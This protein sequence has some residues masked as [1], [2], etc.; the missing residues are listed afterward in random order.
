MTEQQ[1]YIVLKIIGDVEIRTYSPY[2]SANI[3]IDSSY[4]KASNLGFRPLAN[5]IFS[6]GIGL[7]DGNGAFNRHGIPRGQTVC[8]DKDF[9]AFSYPLCIIGVTSTY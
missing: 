9:H 3:K 1:K 4:E 2:V 7:N 5:Y 6:N 8:C